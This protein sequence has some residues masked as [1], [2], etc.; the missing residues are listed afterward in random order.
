MNVFRLR[1][2]LVDDYAKYIRSFIRIADP[3]IDEHVEHALQEG[4]LWPEP[5]LQVSPAY[6]FG[7]TFEDLVARD[8]LHP[9]CLRI[10]ARKAPDGRVEGGI[11]LFRHQVEALRA[12]RAKKP[13]VLT[14]GTGSG[15]SLSYILPIVDDVLR[16]PGGNH[17]KAIVVYPMNA[18]ANSQRGELEKYLKYGYVEAPVTFDRYTGQEKEEERARILANPPDIL[19]TNYMMLELMLTRPREEPLIRAASGLRFLVFDELHTYRGRQGADVALLIRRARA[20]LQARDVLCVGTSATMSSAGTWTARQRDVAD[21]ASRIF[22]VS[23]APENIIGETLRRATPE[24]SETR[25]PMDDLRD[26]VE[27]G[28]PKDGTP[29]DALRKDLLIR[30]IESTVG[31]QREADGRLVRARPLPFGGVGG[32]VDLLHQDTGLPFDGCHVALSRA[33]DLASRTMSPEGR[34]LFGVRLHQFFSKGDTVYATTEGESDRHVTLQAQRFAPG[35]ERAKALLPLAFCR[36]CGQ[37][38]YVVRQLR[39]EDGAI[40]YARR[41]LGDVAGADGGRAGFLYLSTANRWPTDDAGILDRLPDSWLDGDEIARHVRERL[42]QEVYV[43]PDA[44]DGTPRREGQRGHFVAAPFAFCL[45]CGVTYGARQS[46]DFGKLATLGSE[47][48]S[49]ATTILSLSTIQRLREDVSVDAKAR[50]LLTFTDNRQDASLQAGHFNDFAELG[51]LR[52]ALARAVAGTPSGARHDDLPRLVFEALGLP[53]SAYAQNDQVRY[54]QREEVDRALRDAIGYRI[55]VDLRRGW[56]LTS[57]NLEQCGLLVVDYSSLPELCANHADWASTHTA[58]AEAIA[59]QRENI[60]RVL[61]DFMRRELAV[62]VHFLGRAHQEGMQQRSYQHLKSNWALAQVDDLEQ[63]AIVFPCSKPRQARTP[64]NW[65]FVSPRG[66]FGSFLRRMA[67]PD[68]EGEKLKGKD[69]EQILGD[70]FTLL[71]AAG[72]VTPKEELDSG[73]KGYQVSASP[74]RFRPGDGERAYHDPLRIPRP[75]AGGLRTN[76]FFVDFYRG[77]PEG[78]RELE[79][80]E[81][82]AQVASDKREDREDAFRE[83]RLPI[84]YCS[85]TMEL[86]VDIKELDVVGLRNVPPS[87]A[88]YAQRS[89]RAGRSGQAAL[90]FTYCSAGSPHDQFFFRAPER[91]V[92]GVVTAPRLDLANEDLVRSH[93][94]AVWLS[95][96]RIDLKQSLRDI[97]DLAASGDDLKLELRDE[98]KER[99]VDESIRAAA[100]ATAKTALIDALRALVGPDGDVDAWLA[101]ILREVPMRFEWACERWRGLYRAAHAQQRRQNLIAVDASRD[102]RDRDVAKRLREEAEVQ[103]RLLT[104]VDFKTN[105]DFYVYRYLAG[106][107]FLPGYSFPRLP[108]SAFIAGQRGKRGSEEYLSRPRFI[109]ISEFGPRS[110]VYHEGTRYSVTRVIL[111]VSGDDGTLKQR[112]SICETCGYLHPLTEPK[113]P[114]LCERCGA[115]LPPVIAN[116]FRMQNVVTRRSDRITSDEEERQRQGYEIVSAVRFAERNDRISTREA[117]VRDDKGEPLAQLVY[118]DSATLWRM[119]YGWRRRAK[120]DER[121]FMLDI[122]RGVWEKS[123]NAEDTGPEEQM[124]V[125]KERVVPYVVDTRNC[126][127]LTPSTARSVDELATAAYA[128]KNAIERRFQLEERELAVELLP[129]SDEPR[130]ILF[131]EAAEGGAGVLKR[132]AE[133]SAAFR[134]VVRTALALCHFDPDTLADL[135]RAEG[136]SEACEAAC[137][138]CILSYFNQRDHEKLDRQKLVDVL[139]TW[140]ASSLETSPLQAGRRDHAEMLTRFTGSELERRWLRTVENRGLRLPTHAQFNV[141]GVQACADFAYEDAQV[142]VFIDGPPH[143]TPEAKAHDAELTERLEDAGWTVIRFHHDQEWMAQFARFTSVFGTPTSAPPPPRG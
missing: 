11:R 86:G 106:E 92:A 33:L 84:L 21:V 119:N 3:R 32:A 109:A 93:V 20:A 120:K 128:L 38:Y 103:M 138:D 112:A 62:T 63:A 41:D 73:I 97:I 81:H 42:P 18:L 47:G 94:H 125:R 8:E 40:A 36:E 116:F 26:A 122:E 98:I 54:A 101:R 123:G 5:L 55:Y 90:V 102:S 14:T 67:F 65:T 83:G 53:L 34:P 15:K 121:G 30:W 142:L 50:K 56:R 80:R 89:G 91:M 61:L 17:V 25:P 126:L 60:C 139:G 141:D 70:L 68:R 131:Y 27:R 22:G 13:Y 28:G 57:P 107:G 12:A 75:P 78:L 130:A 76:P 45:K 16:R 74:L 29:F 9:E 66:A 134:D 31:I 19:L 111:P 2:Q 59:E 39:R 133:E 117:I 46:R 71:T 88:N 140:A 35:T 113:G 52:A 105:S 118:G 95:A 72:M 49:T 143:D 24:Q 110:L 127:L 136:A 96:S 100:R 77:G 1:R 87:P 99:L 85:P 44:T 4:V 115:A 114:D 23:V 79:A 6:E 69:I 137:Y 135:G 58:L 37:E 104:E 7:E 108:L 10:F 43:R 82:T 51:L 48:R 124:S 64:Y 129:T 132:I